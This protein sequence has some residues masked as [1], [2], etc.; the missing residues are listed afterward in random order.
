MI[1]R[2]A[3]ITDTHIDE[4]FPK[5]VGVNARKNWI[6][7]L[8]DIA[9]RGIGEIIFGGDI[10]EKSSNSWFFESLTVYEICISLGNHDDFSEVIKYYKTNVLANPK[11]LFY[12]RELDFFKCIFLDSSKEVISETQL[13][14]LK[15]ELITTKKVLLFV[16]HPILAI[17][18]MMDKRFSL[19]RRE[20]IQDVLEQVPNDITIFCGH[21][22]MEDHYR[23]K[24]ITQFI[25]PAASYQIEKNPK[26]IK[27]HNNVFGY[28]VIEL[29]EDQIL[30]E[31][32]LL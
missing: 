4:D 16:H 5:T 3:Y 6:T 15:T 29:L 26:E 20:K 11:E 13:T 14:W 32:I 22:H 12:S 10:G 19:K 18:N 24:N 31:V 2:V 30:T 27:V 8:N 25:T 1:K 17:P 21:Y 23:Y 28:R 9:S 7:I